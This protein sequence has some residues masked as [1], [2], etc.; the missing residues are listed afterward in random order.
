MLRGI[1]VGY[2]NSR[3]EL[4]LRGQSKPLRHPPG[5]PPGVLDVKAAESPPQPAQGLRPMMV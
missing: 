2:Q 1:R 3:R 4:R 5:V